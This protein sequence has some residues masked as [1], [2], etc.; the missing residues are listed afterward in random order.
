MSKKKIITTMGLPKNMDKTFGG[1]AYPLRIRATMPAKLGQTVS[2]NV[3]KYTTPKKIIETIMP[4]R[5]TPSSRPPGTTGKFMDSNFSVGSTT[6]LRQGKKYPENIMRSPTNVCAKGAKRAELFSIFTPQHNW[7]CGSRRGIV[8]CYAIRNGRW[9]LAWAN[10]V[11]F[12]SKFFIFPCFVEQL[13][14]S[15]CNA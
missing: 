15:H 2:T 6:M 11:P 12:F 5:V 1:A 4:I 10:F 14:F 9:S 8:F 13:R 7:L 3:H